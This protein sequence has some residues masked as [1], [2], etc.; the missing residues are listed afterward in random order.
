LTVLTLEKLYKA[1]VC[2]NNTGLLCVYQPRF[3]SVKILSAKHVYAWTSTVLS[4]PPVILL[5]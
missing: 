2:V 3:S 5:E 4:E 1:D